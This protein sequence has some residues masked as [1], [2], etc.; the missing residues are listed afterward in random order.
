MKRL[1]L[2][3]VI[4]AALLIAGSLSCL[5]TEN[6]HSKTGAFLESAGKYA[7]AGDWDNAADAFFAARE[8]WMQ[9]RSATAAVTDHEPMEE[10]DRSFVQGE[11]CLEFQNTAAFC[12]YCRSL[13]VM[14]ETISESQ[15]VQWWSFL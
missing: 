6:A 14:V 5:L 1:W 2:G 8:A 9:T 4:L 3:A 15:S 11:T 13:S 12:M 7:T 10:I